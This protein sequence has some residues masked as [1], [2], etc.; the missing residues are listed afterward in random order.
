MQIL[1]AI[2]I[3]ETPEA[4]RILEATR[5]LKA[6]QNPEITVNLEEIKTPEVIK[7][8]GV[9]RILSVMRMVDLLEDIKTRDLLSGKNLLHTGILESNRI[10]EAAKIRE[11]KAMIMLAATTLA[12]STL[13]RTEEHPEALQGT[14]ALIRERLRT[15]SADTWILTNMFPVSRESHRIDIIRETPKK[16]SMRTAEAM[17]TIQR[18]PR[19][20]PANYLDQPW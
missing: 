4:I 13:R 17:T 20:R 15:S 11:G 14:H 18:L 8:L 1:E 10:L 16:A 7:T 9:I 6:M 2:Q 19:C 5:N 12:T 3:S